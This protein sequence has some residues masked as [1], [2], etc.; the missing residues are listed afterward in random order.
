VPVENTEIPEDMTSALSN[1]DS[2]GQAIVD[3]L[4]QDLAEEV[5]PAII[6]HYTT[7][8][9][10]KGILETG[11]IWLTDI[12]HLNDPS[13]ISHGVS[14]ADEILGK[15]GEK[16]PR[17]SGV[18]AKLFHEFLLNGI[19]H[20]AQFFVCSFSA[21]GDDLGQW[22]GYADNGRGYSL[23]FD[24]KALD[25]AFIKEDSEHNCTFYVRYDDASL[26]AIHRQLVDGMFALISLPMGRKLTNHA[27]KSYLRELSVNLS[28]SV[29]QSALFFKHEGYNNEKEYRFFQM[30]AKGVTPPDI[31]LRPRSYELIKY[32]Q[33]DWKRLSPNALKRVVIG[34]A[35]DAAKATQFVAD[36]LATYHAQDVEIVSSRI[37]YRVA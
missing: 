34:P 9:G 37:P 26:K 18:F 3:K 35:A 16:G 20:V 2:I 27:I 7:D 12:F 6:Y 36:C 5:P 8:L 21:N 14:H 11:Q 25:D 31:K 29:V 23:G 30:Y 28:L 13:E 15:K 24:A 10:L 19:Q 17:E 32:R 1:V 33:F 22:R 4:L